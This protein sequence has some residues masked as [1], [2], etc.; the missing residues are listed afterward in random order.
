MNHVSV[1]GEIR[2][3]DRRLSIP[4]W[5]SPPQSCLW[6]GL[7]LHRFRCDT[8]SLYG[9]LQRKFPRCYH[10]HHPLRFHRYS[11]VHSAGFSFPYRG[12]FEGRCSIQLSYWDKAGDG[13]RTHDQSLEGS[14]FTTKLH[15]REANK[16]DGAP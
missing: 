9:S 8:Y 6:S 7:Y 3:P 11:V 12:S 4:L 10:R 16:K 13:N 14:C 5:L 15:P 2:T 1:P